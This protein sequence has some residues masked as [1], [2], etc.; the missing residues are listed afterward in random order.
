MYYRTGNKKNMTRK[1]TESLVQDVIIDEILGLH[2]AHT[3]S[4]LDKKK[5]KT[6]KNTTPERLFSLLEEECYLH[7][8]AC[9]SQK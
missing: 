9:V 3:V 6:K 2:L 5:K 4:F 8:M 7:L 1:T